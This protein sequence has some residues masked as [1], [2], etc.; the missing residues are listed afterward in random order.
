MNLSSLK[1]NIVSFFSN[2]RPIHLII[3]IVLIIIIQII[4]AYKTLSP[5]GINLTKAQPTIAVSPAQEKSL[6]IISLISPKIEYKV[7]EKIPVTINITSDKATAG[8]DLIIKY[9]PNLLTIVQS[10]TKIPVAVGTLFGEYP[11]NKV[12]EGLGLITVS[13]ITSQ[14]AGVM[15]KGAFGTIVFQGKAA[16][17]PKIFLEFTKNSTNDTNLIENKTATDILDKVNNLDLKITP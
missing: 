4:W 3:F 1:Q 13:G 16:G 5:S 17:N 7:G 2:I 8:T 14:L 10:D 11:V 9:D 6:N 12:D 15:P